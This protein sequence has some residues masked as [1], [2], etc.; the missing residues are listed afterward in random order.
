MCEAVAGPA[1]SVT[2]SKP[3]DLPFNKW[4][5]VASYTF[6]KWLLVASYT[7]LQS[8][9]FSCSEGKV[10]EGQIHIDS[11]VVANFGQ[12]F[13]DLEDWGIGDQEFS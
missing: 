10:A 5:L 4:L 1:H 9:R 12:M 2:V 7:F 8:M 13:E 11:W 3:Q 6:N